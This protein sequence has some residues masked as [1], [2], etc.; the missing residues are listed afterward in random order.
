MGQSVSA[1]TS[2]A[3]YRPNVAVIARS[4]HA[5]FPANIT[6]GLAQDPPSAAALQDLS[7]FMK[8]FFYVPLSPNVYIAFF[9]GL[10][11]LGL[12]II[13]AVAIGIYRW[14][15][16]QF[17][18]IRLER[19]ARGLYIVPNALNAFLLCELSFCLSWGVYGIGAF[20]SYRVE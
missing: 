16:G 5:P 12:L 2:Y 10:L 18:I 19:R 11:Y 20:E 8:L 6:A 1:Y 7:G 15:R 17:W 3:D 14:R 9:T 4:P 13:A